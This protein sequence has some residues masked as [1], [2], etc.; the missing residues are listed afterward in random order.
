ML[1][2]T[3]HY[4]AINSWVAPDKCSSPSVFTLSY[5]DASVLKAGQ[6][7]NGR[8]DVIKGYLLTGKTLSGLQFDVAVFTM[9]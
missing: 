9:D 8:D 6:A 5:S 2:E 7:I 4:V 3:L 1:N